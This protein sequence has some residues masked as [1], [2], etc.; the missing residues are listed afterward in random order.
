MYICMLVMLSYISETIT[1]IHVFLNWP[2]AQKGMAEW[3][4]QSDRGVAKVWPR[5]EQREVR[6]V[7]YVRTVTEYPRLLTRCDRETTPRQHKNPDRS[8]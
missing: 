3:R 1:F 4:P 6:Q 7:E 5:C 8:W 2:M